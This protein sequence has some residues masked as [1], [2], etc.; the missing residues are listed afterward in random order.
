MTN[1]LFRKLFGSMVE[2]KISKWAET[3][4]KREKG[5]AG[6]RPKHSTMDHDITLKYLIEKIWDTQGAEAFCCF[7][8]LK[9][10]FDIEP[11][12][13]L[14]DIMEELEVPKELRF[15]VHRL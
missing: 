15:V 14:W 1:P 12:N 10:A 4:G 9:K 11:R 7:M 6:F 3:K 13:K 5:Q 8:D 2:Q